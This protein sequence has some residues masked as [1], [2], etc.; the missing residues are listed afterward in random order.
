MMINSMNM[1]KIQYI[2]K[3]MTLVLALLFVQLATAGTGTEQRSPAFIEFQKA[4]ALWFHTGNGAG[5]VLDGLKGF[6]ML[7]AS[8]KNTNGDFKRVQEGDKENVIGFLAEGGQQLGKSYAWGQ[9]AYNNI[10]VRDSR[11]N[12]AMLDP[13][14]GVPFYPVDP[15]VSD[16]KK[17]N[18]N[19]QMKVASRPLWEKILLGIQ[20]DYFV[21][22][23]AKQVDPRSEQY[24]YSLQVKPGVVAFFGDH[25][26]GANFAYEN[27][28][29]ETR[30]HT[31][32]N[33]QVD[34]PVFVMK[35]LGNHYT[36][37][38][39]GLQSLG[40]FHYNGNLL[41]GEL[42]Y[43]YAVSSVKFLLNGGYTSK[44]ETVIRD[45]SKPRKEGTLKEDKMYANL[46]AV[47][48][49]DDL[50]RIDFSYTKDKVKGIEF[51][52]V[53]DLTYEVQ[54]WVD[55]YSSIR[56]TYE[57]DQMSFAYHYYK[58]TDNAYLWKAGLTA[59]YLLNDDL[60]I[61]PQSLMKIKNLYAGVNGGINIKAG[62]NSLLTVGADV[63]YKHNIDGEYVYGGADPQSIVITQFMSPDFEYLTQ[64]F[65]KIGGQVNF[66]TA[67]G[68]EKKSGVYA[69]LAV[70]YYKPV[71]EEG[72]RILASFGLGFTF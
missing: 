47:A 34:Q 38:I 12:T 54:Q 13:F 58:G 10:T 36:S 32:S 71:K 72:N 51:V 67:F 63:T 14:C 60:Y 15:N 55:V 30:K 21:Y 4:G 64:S 3:A 22:T 7:E 39:G 16:W 48:Q 33:N 52:Q 18:Y 59:D 42:Q 2:N 24:F 49:T 50:H 40:S 23:G 17:Q 62:K 53:L 45:I 8:Y 20:A 37:V 44:V 56:S 27:T 43:A 28:I 70:D 19:L 9:F 25:Q 6:S 26:I 35:G 61:M 1:R 5:L 57:Q 65:Y 31:N 29:R 41:G 66:F 46:A 69:K 11:F 68:K